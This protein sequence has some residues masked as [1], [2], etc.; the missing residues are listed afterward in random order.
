MLLQ[1]PTTRA[2]SIVGTGEKVLRDMFYSGNAKYEPGAVV[3][4]YIVVQHVFGSPPQ[5]ICSTAAIVVA[6][7]MS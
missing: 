4:R 5:C 7:A 3:C 6:T 1:V 2:L